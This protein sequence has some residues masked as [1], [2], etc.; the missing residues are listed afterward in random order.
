MCISVHMRQVGDRSF[1]RRSFPHQSLVARAKTAPLGTTLNQEYKSSGGNR[2]M[3]I[4]GGEIMKGKITREDN[5]LGKIPRMEKTKD[6]KT[7]K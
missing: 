5:H 4:P 1:P 3:K 2:I 6:I 7:R